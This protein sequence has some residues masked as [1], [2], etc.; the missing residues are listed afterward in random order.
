MAGV[1]AISITA[2]FAPVFE[3]LLIIHSEIHWLVSLLDLLCSYLMYVCNCL[4][5]FFYFYFLD[6]CLILLCLCATDVG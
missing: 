6:V 2:T 5:I 4:F 1:V 3:A